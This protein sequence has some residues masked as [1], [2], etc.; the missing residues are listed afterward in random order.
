MITNLV[1]DESIDHAKQLS[2]FFTTIPTSNKTAIIDNG[3]LAN[4]F[5]IT[6]NCIKSLIE[7]Y[8]EFEEGNAYPEQNV[9][10]VQDL[11]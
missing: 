3:K 6:T 8:I 2:I 11:S 4:Q 9:S 10:V 5:D 7:Y 1:V